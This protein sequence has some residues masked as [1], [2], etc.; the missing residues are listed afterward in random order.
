[1]DG[2]AERNALMLAGPLGLGIEWWKII[3]KIRWRNE[4]IK[5]CGLLR[6]YRFIRR[7]ISHS[8][9]VQP[10]RPISPKSTTGTATLEVFADEVWWPDERIRSLSEVGDLRRSENPNELF[11]VVCDVALHNRHAVTQQAFE[12]SDIKD[13][14]TRRGGRM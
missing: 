5:C 10:M 7:S 12:R 4:P 11:F 13:C 6:V 14:G 3:V 1:M 8:E 2:P 9:V